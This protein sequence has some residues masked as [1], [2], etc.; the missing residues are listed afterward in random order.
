MSNSFQIGLKHA[1]GLTLD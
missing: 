1:V